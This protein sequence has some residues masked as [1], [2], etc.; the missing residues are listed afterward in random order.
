VL[1]ADI[2][3]AAADSSF[4][5]SALLVSFGLN[6]LILHVSDLLPNLSV[7]HGEPN[8]KGQS[9]SNGYF[10]GAVDFL[11]ENRNPAG[12]EVIQRT[13]GWLDSGKG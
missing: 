7:G 12:C 5:F 8:G 6:G 13:C 9:N 3:A 11:V 10:G 4:E 2:A 1:F